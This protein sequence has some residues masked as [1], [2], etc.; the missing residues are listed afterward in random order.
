MMKCS[1]YQFTVRSRPVVKLYDGLNPKTLF[2]LCAGELHVRYFYGVI[3]IHHNLRRH[4][5]QATNPLHNIEDFNVLS[6]REIER[7]SVERVI[8]RQPLG[9]E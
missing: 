2:G 3:L 9:Q 5:E 7:F 4:V 6:V 1:R 8:F